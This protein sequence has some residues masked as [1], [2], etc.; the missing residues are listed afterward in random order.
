MT[1]SPSNRPPERPWV[2]GQHPEYT[3]FNLVVSVCQ[4]RLGRVYSGHDFQS[5]KDAAAALAL[6]QA[7]VKQVAYGL[8]V[9][10]VRRELFVEI[11]IALSTSNGYLEG[12]AGATEETRRQIERDLG[13]TA[14]LVMS[15]VIEKMAPECAREVLSML[16]ATHP[17]HTPE[18][19]VARSGG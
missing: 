19:G 16:T 18:D 1:D 3:A 9:E 7:G 17:V 12:W 8:L 10:A 2:T 11:L 4:D 15:R 5:P 13:A 6:P 14:S